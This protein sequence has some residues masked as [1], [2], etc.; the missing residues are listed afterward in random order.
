[1]PG[2]VAGLTGLRAEVPYLRSDL[3][4]VQ[5]KATARALGDDTIVRNPMPIR[6][7]RTAVDSP[8]LEREGFQIAAWPSRVA[9]EPEA[10]IAACLSP[11]AGIPQIQ[12]DYWDETMP[13]IQKLSG[14]REVLPQ[15]RSGVR[16]S[17]RSER[18]HWLGPAGWAH[19]DFEAGEIEQ[20]LQV[21]LDRA[22]RPFQPFSRYVMYQSWRALS[23]P[24]QDYPLALCDGR[25]VAAEDLIPI[26]YLQDAGGRHRVVRSWGSRHSPRHA[27][28]YFPDMTVDEMIVFKGFDSASPGAASTLHVAFDDQAAERPVPRISIESRYFA[29]FD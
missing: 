10:L 20:M 3:D 16:F 19:V 17:P 27:W 25:T 22:G 21:S 23:P 14:A 11:E 26:D 18:R 7:G 28:W 5:V 2:S 15:E 13:L 9:Q 6:N 8:A 24:P 12:W 29:L 4:R 1:M